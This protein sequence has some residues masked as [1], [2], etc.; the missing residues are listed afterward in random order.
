YSYIMTSNPASSLIVSTYMKGMLTK[1][2]PEHAY[3]VIKRNQMPGG[4]LGNKEDIN[5]YTRKGF[6]PGNAGITIE[7]SFQ[8]WGV[9][10]MAYKL[11]KQK[12]YNFFYK[13]SQSWRNCF[14]P[15]S[16]LLFPK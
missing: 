12:D 10:Q 9:A 4:M 11:G 15:K 7:A 1:V 14:E 6:W 13:R 5:F 2:S 3:E 8:D 16:K